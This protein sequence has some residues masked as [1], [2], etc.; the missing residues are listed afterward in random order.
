M[1]PHDFAALTRLMDA[2]DICWVGL[3]PWDPADFADC[4][5]S[6]PAAEFMAAAL[7]ALP[8]LLAVVRAA[9]DIDFHCGW[10]AEQTSAD[11]PVD[12]KAKR[13][14]ALRAALARF[15]NVGEVR[16]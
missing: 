10:S 12:V 11:D 13:L 14:V 2:S 9:E 6:P 5:Y 16:S 3:D 8:D 4:G 15:S 1:T 7:N